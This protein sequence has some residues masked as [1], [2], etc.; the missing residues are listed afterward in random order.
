MP[1]IYF[2]EAGNEREQNFL[3]SDWTR[4]RRFLLREGAGGIDDK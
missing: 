2:Q 3:E 4:D 1:G